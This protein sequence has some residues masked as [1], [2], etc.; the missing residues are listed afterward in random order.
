M[1]LYTAAWARA[2]CNSVGCLAQRY[3]VVKL[4]DRQE[5]S[6]KDKVV[7]YVLCFTFNVCQ[8]FIYN[9]APCIDGYFAVFLNDKA[10]RSI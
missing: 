9:A 10:A 8:A 7:W 6:V 1:E 4:T 3:C 2:V 5:L